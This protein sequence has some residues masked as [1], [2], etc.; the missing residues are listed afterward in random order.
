MVFFQRKA[1]VIRHIC[2][3]WIKEK[4]NIYLFSNLNIKNIG[5]RLDER[6]KAIEKKKQQKRK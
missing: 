4:R 6:K 5:G 1:K 3:L 2:F